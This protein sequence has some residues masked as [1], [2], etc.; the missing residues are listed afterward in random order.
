MLSGH[1]SSQNFQPQS[2]RPRKRWIDDAGETVQK[3]D[4]SRTEGTILP[5]KGNSHSPRRLTPLMEGKKFVVHCI[6]ILK[7]SD[8]SS[9]CILWE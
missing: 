4:L 2:G 8:V 5:L 1:N 9:K 7:L 6:L 3:D